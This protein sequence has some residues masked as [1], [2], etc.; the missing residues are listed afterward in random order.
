M[1]GY[2]LDDDPALLS[3]SVCFELQDL[4]RAAAPSTYAAR[5]VDFDEIRHF[6]GAS[7]SPPYP[8]YIRANQSL[9]P[10]PAGRPRTRKKLK[11][12]GR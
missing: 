7:V 2:H 4:E 11:R 12:N 5:R 10:W 8:R 6:Y 1:H 3:A 9:E